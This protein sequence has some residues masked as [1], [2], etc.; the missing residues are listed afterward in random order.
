M[1]SPPIF[2]VL[3]F[4]MFGIALLT[5]G[6]NNSVYAHIPDIFVATSLFVAIIFSGPFSGGHV[7]PAVTMGMVSI[8]CI[9][10][11][12]K[13]GGLPVSSAAI[14]WTG[15]VLGGIVGS[16]LGVAT[17]GKVN[18]PTMAFEVQAF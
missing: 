3:F 9:G 17:V 4:E 1:G 8:L 14:Y 15:Q 7:N 10:F 12:A 2:T 5:L 6:V 11:V 16:L 13:N 18:A